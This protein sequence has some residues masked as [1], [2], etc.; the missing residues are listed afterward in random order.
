MSTT[1]HTQTALD[2]ALAAK[3]PVIYIDSPAGVWLKVTNTESSS[4]VA[5]ES[6]SV[7]A[8]GSSR[9]VARGSSRV[10]AR[11]SSRVVARES[12]SVVA[13]ESSSVEARES[14]SVEAA[15]YTAVHLW[16]QRVTLDAKGAVIDMTAVD[17]DDSATWVEYHGVKVARG[18]ALVFKAVD[19]DLTAGR[20]YIPTEYA[21]GKTVKATDWRDN[22]ACGHGL[23]FSPSPSGAKSHHES[24]T[25]FL[26]VEVSVAKMVALRDKIKAPSCNVLFEVDIHGDKIAPAKAAA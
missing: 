9:V 14:S 4:V 3:T 23:H 1:V 11:G 25:R 12:S 7:E 6:S 10:E 24:A 19:D 2:A 16:S 26:A 17:L 20:S 8:W 18:K 5:R 21:I 13:W 15:K 22:K